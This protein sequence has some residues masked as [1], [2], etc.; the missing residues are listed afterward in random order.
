MRFLLSTSVG[1]ACSIA[2]S[3]LGA[4]QASE[5]GRSSGAQQ[6]TSA[7]STTAPIE[8]PLEFSNVDVTKNTKRR[9]GAPHVAVNPTNPNNVVVLASSSMGYTRDCLP[10]APGSDCESVALQVKGMPPLKQ[11]RGFAR[12]A[13][14]MDIGVFVSFDRGKTFKHVDVSDLVP[15]DDPMVR[16]R[17]EG[18]IAATLDGSFYIGFNAIDWGDWES[19]PQTFFPNGGVGV[20][21]STDGGLTW[22]WT[23]YSFTPADWPYGGADPITGTFYVTSGIAGMTPLG[24][25]SNGD[26]NSPVGKI[27]DRWISSTNDGYK[28]T[29]PQPLGGN[30]GSKHI[31]AGH[32]SVAAAH[33]VMA[34]MFVASSPGSCALCFKAPPMRASRGVDLECRR[35]Q[36]SKRHRSVSS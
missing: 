36:I 14:F 13:G 27:A 2:V 9:F 5:Q 1:I 7:P 12:T 34:T 21:K 35:R 17:G 10:P 15:P 16:A 6:K 24:P 19:T 30:D 25:R 29:E 8:L 18:P 26:P 33:G 23:S 28:W 20:I 4:D 32:S 22:K 11:P 31:G 3:A